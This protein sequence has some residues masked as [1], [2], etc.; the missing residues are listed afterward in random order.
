[1]KNNIFQKLASGLLFA[2]AWASTAAWAVNDL[3]GRPRQCDNSIFSQRSTKIA[4]EQ[5]LVALVHADHLYSHL[6]RRVCV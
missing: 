4:E 1:M 3:P 5:G 2:A 6:R